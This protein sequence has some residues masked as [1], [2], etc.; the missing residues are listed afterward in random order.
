MAEGVFRWKHLRTGGRGTGKEPETFQC[1]GCKATVPAPGSY[2]DME[3]L[4][5][6]QRFAAEH[7]NCVPN[8]KKYG[9]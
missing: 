9:Y 4:R 1:G 7:R 3:Y 5:A 6:A 8:S 2:G